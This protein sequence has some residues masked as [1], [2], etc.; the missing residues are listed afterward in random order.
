MAGTEFCNGT[1]SYAYSLMLV[2]CY[3][4]SGTLSYA[5]IESLRSL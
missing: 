2:L 5:R 1:L 3:E 4:I